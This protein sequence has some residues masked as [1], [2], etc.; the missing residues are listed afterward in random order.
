MCTVLT[1]TPLS[2]E[3]VPIIMP[4]CGEGTICKDICP[5]GAIHGYTWEVSMN[6]DFIVNVYHCDC[7][8]KCLVNCPWTQ[9]YMK[10]NIANQMSII[11]S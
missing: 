8:L 10:D 2:T 3:N 5:T 9:K 1:N 4:K 11:H 7:C 6:R